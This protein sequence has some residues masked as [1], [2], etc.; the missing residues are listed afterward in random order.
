[1]K[2]FILVATAAALSAASSAALAAIPFDGGDTITPGHTTSGSTETWEI[3]PGGANP[4]DRVFLGDI[5]NLGGNLTLDNG[6]G[7]SSILQFNGGSFVDSMAADAARTIKADQFY[8]ANAATVTF[9]GDNDITL[10]GE[11]ETLGTATFRNTL[12]AGALTLGTSLSQI[13]LANITTFDGAG[14]TVLAGSLVG[15]RNITVGGTAAG[16]TGTEL[17]FNGAANAIGTLTATL[18]SNSKVVIGPNARVDAN[19]AATLN[20]NEMEFLANGKLY[21]TGFSTSH[22]LTMA[23]GALLDVGSTGQVSFTG[24]TR[25]VTLDSASQIQAGRISISNGSGAN[26]LRF[27]IAN[28]ST[29]NGDIYVSSS[30]SGFI[31]TSTKD[32]RL[33]GNLYVNTN[34]MLTNDITGGG[35]LYLGKAATA[36]GVV[37]DEDDGSFISS[38]ASRIVINANSL[39]LTG[40]A[41]SKTVI[42]GRFDF[43]NA[44]GEA[45]SFGATLGGSGDIHIAS[46]VNELASLTVSTGSAN[47]SNLPDL[48][49]PKVVIDAGAS[50]Y[51]VGETTGTANSHLIVNGKLTTGNFRG[52]GSGT[53]LTF[54]SA[55]EMYV[56]TGDLSYN[57][58][59]GAAAMTLKSDGA[60]GGTKVVV[61]RGNFLTN[62][63][64]VLE[65]DTKLEVFGTSSIGTDK[66]IMM[67][68]GSEYTTTG[69]STNNTSSGNS[70]WYFEESQSWDANLTWDSRLQFH[71]FDSSSGI[72]VNNTKVIDLAYTGN[73]LAYGGRN[74]MYLYLNAASGSSLTFGSAGKAVNFT[75]WYDVAGTDPETDL[76]ILIPTLRT[77]QLD[78]AGTAG[79]KFVF[80]GQYTGGNINVAAGLHLRFEHAGNEVLGWMGI[81]NNALSRISIGAGAD[82]RV[83]DNVGMNNNILQLENNA[84][85]ATG[86]GT[87]FGSGTLEA[88]GNVWFDTYA[89][90]TKRSDIAFTGTAKFV[91]SGPVATVI[92][93]GTVRFDNTVT[94]ETVAANASNLHLKAETISNNVNNNLTVANNMLDSV[95]GTYKTLTLG[96]DAMSDG[97]GGTKNGTI[98]VNNNSGGTARNFALSGAG[99]IVVLSDIVNGTARSDSGLTYS[100]TATLTLAGDNTYSGLTTINSGTVLVTGDSS[101]ATGAVNVNNAGTKLGGTGRVGGLTTINSG[102]VLLADRL[103][104]TGGL[105]LGAAGE[106]TVRAMVADL[107]TIA[108]DS[109][110]AWGNAAGNEVKIDLAGTG[111][112]F[113]KGSYLLFDLSEAGDFDGALLAGSM[114]DYTSF[115]VED[116]AALGEAGMNLGDLWLFYDEDGKTFGTRGLYIMGVI[117]EPSTWLLLGAG[118]AF[119]VVFRRRKA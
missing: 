45:T 41:G 54:G 92:N 70:H 15:G 16:T 52:H 71:S 73:V 12:S 119:L 103:T 3:T 76:P 88:A 43:R 37:Y 46:E 38:D 87:G 33:A 8:V 68:A 61:E 44:L 50:V 22:N 102:A 94:F 72:N 56:T 10:A 81:G 23:A 114:V 14:R 113:G 53:Y 58:A 63:N 74:N 97:A 31:V 65:R 28:A 86:L 64:V 69:F 49:K 106:K 62:S 75:T 101:G 100:G 77:P 42:D 117:P 107:V 51:V 115:T 48:T 2:K 95:A 79:N 83:R 18:N 7:L 108:G 89:D 111:W 35:I 1:M 57:T 60:G 110:L 24:N 39:S 13:T 98:N 105:D 99:D 55:A 82:V 30:N 25:T 11:I 17:H 78:L 91:S 112:Q 6:A 85:L 67:Y 116:M 40:T 84:R 4:L 9:Q 27:N 36:G 47:T 66:T 59:G 5:L 96:T 20:N 19:G 93:A 34:M 21:A 118:A 104:F 29:L 26:H 32:I 90:S 80:A 109:D